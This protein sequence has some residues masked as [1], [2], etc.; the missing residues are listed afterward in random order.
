LLRRG[1]HA[2][3]I[4]H[5]ERA[6]QVCE[7]FDV[8]AVHATTAGPLASASELAQRA[9]DALVLVRRAVAQAATIGD[10]IGHGVRTTTRAEALLAA[11]R[12][13]EGRPAAPP[14]ALPGRLPPLRRGQPSRAPA[15]RPGAPPRPRRGLDLVR[16]AR[17]P[18]IEG[19]SLRLL[20]EVLAAQDPPRLDE[21]RA[22]LEA[23]LDIAGGG[24]T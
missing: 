16:L 1:E 24:G 20:G 7:S 5:L 8:A 19:W 10:P 4:T 15:R 23:A 6:L 11:G 17:G 2:G 3:A 22:S 21:A 18:G 13:S 14:T 9:E 12:P